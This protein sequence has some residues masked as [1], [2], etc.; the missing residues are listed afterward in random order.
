MRKTILLSIVSMLLLSLQISAQGRSIKD[1]PQPDWN[2]ELFQK[3]YKTDEYVLVLTDFEDTV[4]Y[5]DIWTRCKSIKPDVKAIVKYENQLDEKDYGKHMFV[6]GPIDSFERW[7]SFGLP[8]EKIRGG[9]KFGPYTFTDKDDGILFLSSDASRVVYTGNSLSPLDK[10]L[11]TLGGLFQYTIVQHGVPAYFGNLVNDQFNSRGHI[12]LRKERE[13]CLSYKLE[14]RYYFFHCSDKAVDVEMLKSRAS[15]FDNYCNEVVLRLELDKPDYK[16]DCYIYTDE[17]E[18]LLLSGT[19]GRGGVTYGKEI[20]TL[21]F[22]AIEHES[23]HVLFNSDVGQPNNNFFN[24]GIRQYYEYTTNAESLEASRKTVRKYLNEPIEKWA[25]GSVYFFSTPSENGWPVAY[26]AS[27][28]FVKFLI[29]RHGLEKFKGF[30]KK[31]D[32]DIDTGFLEVY[33]KPLVDM[34]KEWKNAEQT[35]RF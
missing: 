8:I 34:V 28:L 29:D 16:I 23:V 31:V 17:N 6:C 33:G 19:P 12:D 24:E 2:F 21:G 26:P 4:T 35:G 15:V 20:H 32:V 13:K 27:G 18:K 10:L 30:Y 11:R 14:S 3:F 7:K 5:K 22:D 25:N 1:L 9:F